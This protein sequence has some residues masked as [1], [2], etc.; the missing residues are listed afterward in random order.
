MTRRLLVLAAFLGLVMPALAQ[1]PPAASPG[2][3][4]SA[5]IAVEHAWA[6]ATSA[7]AKTGAV[8]FTVV[9]NGAA[10]DRLVAAAAPTVAEKAQLHVTIE[11]HG[12]MKMRPLDA[13]DVKPGEPATL[14]PGAQHLML[15]GLKTPLK[16]GDTFPVTLT[17][18]KAGD[19]NVTVIV[20]KAGAMGMDHSMMPGMKM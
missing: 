5:P 19:V 6:R 7:V 17:F 20:Q 16:V 8:Y 18:E 9:D 11:D 1:T 12:V 13:L 4:S 14:A 10:P 15:V 2:T 3:S